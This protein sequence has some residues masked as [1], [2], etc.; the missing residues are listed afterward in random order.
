MYGGAVPA[1]A[2]LLS[3]A[4]DADAHKVQLTLPLDRPL[5]SSDVITLKD[6]GRGM[7]WEEVNGHYLVIGRNRRQSGSATRGGR[8]VMGRKGIGKLAGFG[9]ARIVEVRTVRNRWLTHFAMDYRDMT[10][11]TQS[12]LRYEPEILADEKSAESNS[13]AVI[14]R[15]LLL[16]RAINGDQFRESLSRRFA[17]LD[18]E[19]QVIVNGRLLHKS[20]MKLA[21]RQPKLPGSVST[22][23][24]EGFGEVKYWYGFTKDTILDPDARGLAILVRGRMAQPPSQLGISGGVFGQ[25]YLEYLTGEITAD[26]LDGNEDYISTDRQSLNWQEAGPAALQ[27]W[28]QHIIRTALR[29]FDEDRRKRQVEKILTALPQDEGRAAAE[30]IN[31]LPERVGRVAHRLMSV[32]R[33]VARPDSKQTD[34]SSAVQQ[35]L[36]LAEHAGRSTSRKLVDPVVEL[37]DARRKALEPYSGGTLPSDT[38]TL[39]REHPWLILSPWRIVVHD[40]ELSEDLDESCERYASLED[41]AVWGVR[42]ESRRYVIAVG[43]EGVQAEKALERIAR[44]ITTHPKPAALYLIAIDGQARRQGFVR[45]AL[46]HQLID[47]ALGSCKLMLSLLTSGGSGD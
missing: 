25:H 37:L 38:F 34:L 35:I 16:T 18:S 23:K 5:V 46:L 1:I 8:P 9:I 14:L 6:D 28:G 3:N 31:A 43:V 45:R 2:E 19:F 21:Y 39:L 32:Y 27:V 33:N 41:C 17:V 11:D 30:R 7:S 47:E 20:E 40:E 4:W 22:E 42:H 13:T 24:L 44:K 26:W 12:H 29:D 10:S 36:E 15:E